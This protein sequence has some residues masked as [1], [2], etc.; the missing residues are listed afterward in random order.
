MTL[1]EAAVKSSKL[2]NPKRSKTSVVAKRNRSSS[3]ELLHSLRSRIVT[4]R[5]RLSD[6]KRRSISTWAIGCL[7]A[8]QASTSSVAPVRFFRA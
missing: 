6:S 4:N 2:P 5:P 3:R 1:E 8:M 7:K